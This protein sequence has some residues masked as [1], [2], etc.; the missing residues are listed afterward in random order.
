MVIDS[1]INQSGGCRCGSAKFE[2]NLADAKTLVCHCLDCQK[3]LGAPFSVFTVVKASQF[4]WLQEPTGRISFSEKAERI[5]CS[6]CGTYLK[7]EGKG[8][9]T[10]AEINTI[11]LED[12]GSISIDEEIY[13]KD[14]LPWVA[15]IDGAEQYLA[16]RD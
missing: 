6:D 7:W 3:H 9:E 11:A 10:E 8:A 14:R 12:P 5:F 13:V 15:A 1:G 4:R 16:D 2:I